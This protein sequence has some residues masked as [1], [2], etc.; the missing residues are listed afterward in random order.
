[1]WLLACAVAA[2]VDPH[3]V[4]QLA[5]KL[6]ALEQE[7]GRLVVGVV[8]PAHARAV[9]GATSP[10][11]TVARLIDTEDY[12]TELARAGRDA[13]ASLGV[14]AQLDGAGWTLHTVV[15]GP[16]TPRESL[17]HVPSRG[18]VQAVELGLGGAVGASGFYTRT[19]PGMLVIP[20][21][22][23][24]ATAQVEVGFEAA[25]FTVGLMSA[26]TFLHFA[27]SSD[28]P[29]LPLCLLSGG[30]LFGTD[31]VRAGP[32]GEVGLL[33]AD[34]GFRVI[35]LS[36]RTDWGTARGVEVRVEYLPSWGGRVAVL[37]SWSPPTGRR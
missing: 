5:D 6:D 9:H 33:D 29:L 37:Y 28:L 4:D 14:Y 11:I 20:G 27:S 13:G 30:F 22:S 26:P 36:E 24:I 12:E 7:Y 35:A 8:D 32:F 10:D 23:P 31:R 17:S 16:A 19:S 3:R 2:A 15:L 1:M 18:P 34:L 25:R 21:A